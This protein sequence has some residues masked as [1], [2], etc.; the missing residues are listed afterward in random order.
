MQGCTTNTTHVNKATVSLDCTGTKHFRIVPPDGRIHNQTL[1]DYASIFGM[2]NNESTYTVEF[3]AKF[4]VLPN[5]YQVASLGWYNGSTGT[6]TDNLECTWMIYYS[7]S[8][9]RLYA[10]NDWSSWSNAN[11]INIGPAVIDT[12]Y[13]FRISRNAINGFNVYI[14]NQLVYEYNGNWSAQYYHLAAGIR[15]NLTFG[16][17]GSLEGYYEN[18]K[19]YTTTFDNTTNI[20]N[21]EID[22]AIGNTKLNNPASHTFPSTMFDD[23]PNMAVAK[24]SYPPST[25]RASNTTL[26]QYKT[27]KGVVVPII[28]FSTEN[29]LQAVVAADGSVFYEETTPISD[30]TLEDNPRTP[31]EQ[32][33]NARIWY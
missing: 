12:W 24:I 20:F 16:G 13:D 27:F 26:S 14:N 17:P 25:I 15:N 1:V 5:N 9:F 7:S 31:E 30:A 19:I 32:V 22:Q 18:V 28:V 33:S 4:T 8:T 11:N 10:E 6:A 21:S 2:T 29:S 3:S 23:S